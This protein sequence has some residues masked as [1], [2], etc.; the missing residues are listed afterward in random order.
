MTSL[1]TNLGLIL[2]NNTTDQSGSFITWQKD[3][4]GSANSNMTTIDRWAGEASGSI[5]SLDAAVSASMTDLNSQISIV[6]ASLVSVDADITTILGNLEKLDEFTGA[7]QASFT[8]LDQTHKH[9]LVM[10]LAGCGDST[11]GS[12]TLNLG[13]DFNGDANSYSYETM[14]WQR[15]L[16]DFE[17]VSNWTPGAIIIGEV[18]NYYDAVGGYGTGV[19]AIIPN[20][21]SSSGFYKN[22]MGFTAG[23]HS[24]SLAGNSVAGLKGGVWKSVSAITS[25]RFFLLNAGNS[26]RYNFASGTVLSVYGFG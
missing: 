18:G 22:A 8:S 9:L 13:C 2:Y 19:F 4:S 6:S 7:G 1:S 11:L 24:T 21:S 20:Y 3:L 23:Y 26:R 10:G 14:G 5:T 15:T 17:T 25:I 12:G 16:D